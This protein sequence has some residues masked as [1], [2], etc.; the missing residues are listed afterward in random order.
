M[1][2]AS[3]IRDGEVT[4]AWKKNEATNESA[5]HGPTGARKTGNVIR[6]SVWEQA[7]PG[8]WRRAESSIGSIR[9][10][11]GQLLPSWRL[12]TLPSHGKR[13]LHATDAFF[14]PSLR[15]DLPPVGNNISARDRHQS[16]VWTRGPRAPLHQGP[17]RQTR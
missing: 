17:D 7:A 1:P 11:C 9:H 2:R 5:A 16:R 13:R 4:T 6:P 10:G 15:H 12:P 8:P 14:T 3:A